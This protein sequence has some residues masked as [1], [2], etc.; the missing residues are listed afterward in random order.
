MVTESIFAIQLHFCELNFTMYQ[1]SYLNSYKFG[2]TPA[3][4][5]SKNARI[6]GTNFIHEQQRNIFIS[7]FLKQV[8]SHDRVDGFL[9]FRLINVFVVDQHTLKLFPQL[10][11]QKL[12]LL[13]GSSSAPTG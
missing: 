13:F 10:L 4:I 6:L 9:Y 2:T 11:V 5:T 3:T 8:Q 1:I 12:S 7:D